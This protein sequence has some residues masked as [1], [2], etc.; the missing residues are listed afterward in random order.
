MWRKKQN[1][2]IASTNQIIKLETSK[3]NEAVLPPYTE[4]SFFVVFMEMGKYINEAVSTDDYTRTDMTDKKISIKMI[5]RVPMYLNYML[6]IPIGVE[7]ISATKIAKDLN[8]GE[9]LVRKDL[10][11]ISNRGR[12]K[13]GH[14][15]SELLDDIEKFLDIENLLNAV[16]IG[17]K[18]IIEIMLK[19]ENFE[20]AGVRILAG[21]DVDAKEKTAFEKIIV[22]P[23]SKIFTVCEEQKISM[24][25]L[26][27]EI[28]HADKIL[29]RLAEAGIDA[30]L[31]CTT[32]QLQLPSHV[33]VKNESF[34]TILMKMQME[35]KKKYQ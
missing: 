21:F 35:L 28:D 2:R 19:Y 6:S 24:V 33:L 12:H 23:L 13:I 16:I 5:T 7:H 31:N 29:N 4:H 25:I 11:Q 15:C 26:L 14:V 34:L 27:D 22:Y 10:A 17:K 9:A 8:L 3:N 20:N 32:M 18:D 30:I 1:V